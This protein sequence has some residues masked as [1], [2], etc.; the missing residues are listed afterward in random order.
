MWVEKEGLRNALDSQ[1]EWTK[2]ESNRELALLNII[3]FILRKHYKILLEKTISSINYHILLNKT[4]IVIFL[5][6]PRIDCECTSA[7]YS[8]ALTLFLGLLQSLQTCWHF[9]NT[10]ERDFYAQRDMLH[11]SFQLSLGVLCTF[12]MLF[13]L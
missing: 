2:Y 1:L 13:L 8:I 5:L 4:F 7:V 12:I 3:N 9:C 11:S 10:K 6:L